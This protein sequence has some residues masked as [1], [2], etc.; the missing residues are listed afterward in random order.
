MMRLLH[1]IGV[2][3][4]NQLHRMVAE[5]QSLWL[6][7]L[8]ILIIYVLGISL[9]GVFS[10]DFSL[11][12][13][14]R[15]GV[16]EGRAGL[17]GFATE[18]LRGLP[19]FFTVATEADPVETRR[20]VLR[21]ESDAAVIVPP[22]FPAEP[23]AIVAP[24]GSV[25]AGILDGVLRRAAGQ[26]GVVDAADGAVELAVTEIVPAAPEVGSEGV[27]SP[28][29]GV[30]SYQ[31]YGIGLTVMFAMF[32]AH[33]AMTYCAGDLA[34]GAY[35]RIRANGVSR[36][37]YLAGG[38]VSAMVMGAAFILFMRGATSLVFGV[39]WGNWLAWA[40]LTL[41]GAAAVAAISFLLMSLAPRN[42]KKVDDAGGSLFTILAILGGSTWPLHTMPDWLARALAWLPNR[43]VLEGYFKVASGGGP[44]TV[45]DELR[46]LGVATLALFAA[47][48]VVSG[49]R[50]RRE[51]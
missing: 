34:S 11:A 33:V 50:A 44:A 1:R 15:V 45:A 5:G 2:M 4:V 27:E 7:I 13:P 39:T 29:A 46:I 38:Y 28:W 32:A 23:V 35:A 16:V 6:V 19:Q 21:Q 12:E 26:P 37:A 17:G 48:W 51:A 49:V 47:A 9:Q 43:V 30:G 36:P 41:A 24:P 42:P 14:Y 20:R 3:V 8:P 40:I 18:A 31:Y 25:V 10:S 22:G